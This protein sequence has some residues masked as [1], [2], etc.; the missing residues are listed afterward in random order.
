M[1]ICAPE[2]V[3]A[4]NFPPSI[5]T[6]V[7]LISYSGEICDKHCIVKGSATLVIW[8]A[9]FSVTLLSLISHDAVKGA[10]QTDCY[11]REAIVFVYAVDT[12]NSCNLLMFVIS[13]DCEFWGKCV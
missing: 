11:I 6:S 8:S 7:W 1:R 9:F 3:E 4:K 2:F 5:W 12:L 13:T 10:R